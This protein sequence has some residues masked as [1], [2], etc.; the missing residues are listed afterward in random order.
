MKLINDDIL[1]IYYIL[2][3]DVFIEGMHIREDL[4][5]SYND[6]FSNE[7]RYDTLDENNSR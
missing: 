6:D 2:V 4:S 7:D 3:S 1:P 5:F